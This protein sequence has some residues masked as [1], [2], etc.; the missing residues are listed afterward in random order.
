MCQSEAQKEC[1]ECQK[2]EWLTWTCCSGPH[3]LLSEEESEVDSTPDSDTI[4]NSA[5]TPISELH[6]TSES[7]FIST[8][9]SDIAC[10]GPE[11]ALAK[12]DH[13]LYVDLPPEAECI[14]A[15]AMTSQRLVEALQKYAKVEAEIMEYL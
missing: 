9:D 6:S 7:E 8:F 5:S 13:L 3:P 1:W 2:V 4:P 15:S 12:G 10:L 14:C 11:D